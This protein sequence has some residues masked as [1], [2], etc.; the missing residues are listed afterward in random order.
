MSSKKIE[1][2]FD[3]GKA[4]IEKINENVKKR[5]RK[6]LTGSSTTKVRDHLKAKVV[7]IEDRPK[8]IKTFDKVA[9][10]LGVLNICFTEYFVV[11]EP[12]KYWMWYSVVVPILLFSRWRHFKANQMQYFLLDFCYSVNI[13]SF[14]HLYLLYNKSYSDQ[15]FRVAFILATGPLPAAIPVWM[16]SFVFHDVDRTVSVYIHTLPMC[17]YYTL[18]LRSDHLCT[19]PL[20]FIDYFYSILFYLAWQVLYLIQTEV[21]DKDKLESEH[22]LT[23]L[24]WLSGNTKNALSGNVL[25]FCKMIGIYGKDETFQEKE[26]RT[27]LVFVA[28]Q[29]IFTITSMIP[30]Y[31]CWISPG[32]N[33]LF[34][35]AIFTTAI[36]FGGSYYVDVFSKRYVASL[37]KKERANAKENYTH[38]MTKDC[39]DE[40]EKTTSDNSND[41]NMYCTDDLLNID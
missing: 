26:M 27:K 33:L 5:L 6:V 37:E 31:Y 4:R 32:F 25:K 21:F 13:F 40:Y 1:N 34:I 19:V 12:A 17:L 16:N 41:C 39:I 20:G 2:V 30:T 38:T 18:R 36:W 28:S 9:F 29:A 8:L 23:S 35:C 14:V 15:V 10:T 22:L 11:T 7:E 24:K 3:E